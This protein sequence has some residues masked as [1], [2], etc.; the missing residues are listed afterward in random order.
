MSLSLFFFYISY[1]ICQ[2]HLSDDGGMPI[3]ADLIK[4]AA[5]CLLESTLQ[6]A[7][8]YPSILNL[9]EHKLRYVGT[10]DR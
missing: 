7:Q 9:N 10:L 3:L 5:L 1:H 6:M 2:I 8:V 4:T